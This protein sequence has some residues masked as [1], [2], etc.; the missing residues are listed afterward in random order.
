MIFYCLYTV[1]HNPAYRAKY[2][3]KLKRDADYKP[4]VIDLLKRVCTVSVKT[5]E[6][7][8]EMENS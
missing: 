7:V 2:E 8:G 3:L 6:I 1:L 4:Q 5:M